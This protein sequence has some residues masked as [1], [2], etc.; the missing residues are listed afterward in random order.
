MRRLRHLTL[1]LTVTYGRIVSFIPSGLKMKPP[2]VVVIASEPKIRHLL[3]G[4]LPRFGFSVL[5]ARSTEEG[6]ELYRK[7]SPSVLLIDIRIW[8]RAAPAFVA[9]D[10]NV[11]CCLIS[12]GGYCIDDFSYDHYFDVVTRPLCLP[13]V[14]QALWGL[15]TQPDIIVT[16]G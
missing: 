9:L 3:A 8:L 4:T 16:V 2:T 13:D 12:S 11:K 15:V 1:L 5:A 10:P 6:L 14:A 7:E